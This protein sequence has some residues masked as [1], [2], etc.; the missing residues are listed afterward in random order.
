MLW[1]V[2]LE[3]TLENPLDYKEIKPANHKGNQFWI[4]IGRTDAEAETPGLVTWWEELTLWKIPWCWERLKVGGEGMTEDEMAG[5]H[6]QLNGH[7]FEYTLGVG[8]RQGGLVCC[9][10]WGHKESDT[11][12]QLNWVWIPWVIFQILVS[13]SFPGILPFSLC[14]LCLYFN[15]SLSSKAFQML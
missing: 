8:D 6:H 2:V 15:A 9:S 4:F 12:E 1:T 7:E 13:I 10:S 5:F 3:K 11:T 14:L